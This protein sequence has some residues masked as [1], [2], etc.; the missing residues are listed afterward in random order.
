MAE[1]LKKY[2]SWKSALESKG[3]K[4]NKIGKINV[5][6]SKKKDSCHICGRKDM[7]NAVLCK[8]S[9]NLKYGRCAK[10]KRVTNRPAIDHKCRKCKGCHKTVV[11]HKKIA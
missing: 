1:L 9:G 7:A 5:K 4:V 8:S 10:I 6:P 2:Y 3:L 11:D